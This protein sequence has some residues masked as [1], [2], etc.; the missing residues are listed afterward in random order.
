[1]FLFC[2]FVFPLSKSD[3]IVFKFQQRTTEGVLV[4]ILQQLAWDTVCADLFRPFPCL[5]PFAT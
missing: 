3:N 1:M 5:I 2:L 4:C